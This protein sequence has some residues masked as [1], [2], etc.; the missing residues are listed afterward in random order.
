G[1][2]LPKFISSF[3][4]FV[5]GV[6]TKGFGRKSLYK[7]AKTSMGRRQCQWTE[8]EMAMWEAVF[9]MT[10]PIRYKAVQKGRRVMLTR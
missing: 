5:N 10:A 9:E 4:W 8:L 7:T 3:A 1:K 2:P 6:V